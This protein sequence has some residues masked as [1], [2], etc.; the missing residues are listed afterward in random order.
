MITY[1]NDLLK[2]LKLSEIEAKKL[3]H[4]YVGTEHF[5]LSILNSDTIYKT[6]CDSVN[7]Y[8]N[9]VLNE[10]NKIKSNRTNN[11]LIYTPLLKRLIIISTKNN[12]VTL[13]EVFLKLIENSEGIACSII[14]N[15]NIVSMDIVEYNPLKDKDDKSL[16]I[17]K[18]LVDIIKNKGC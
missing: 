18:E 14:N 3:N 4:Q 10:I 6:Y 12:I 8:Y 5:L 16:N 7:L 11:E 2:I 13:K 17:V 9:D 15:L 1:E